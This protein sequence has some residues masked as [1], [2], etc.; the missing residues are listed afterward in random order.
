M[1]FT[2]TLQNG[3]FGELPD[4]C[5]SNGVVPRS[6]ISADGKTLT[7]NLGTREQGTAIAVQTPVVA[8][9][10]TGSQLSATGTIGGQATNLSPISLV[11]EF[12]MDMRWGTPSVYQAPTETY[13]DVDFQWTLNLNRGSEPGPQTIVYDVTFNSAQA[14]AY[15]VGP[16][17]CSPFTG[18]WPADGHPWS[19]G[20][21][22]AE[23]TTSFVDNCTFTQTGPNT[24]RLTL[25]G[26]NYSPASAPTEDST[27]AR[28][29]TD[30]V[31]VA[32]GSI[33]L[34]FNT[35]A[36]N[37]AIDLSAT[38]PAYTS[39]AGNTA[40]DDPSN[41]TSSKSWVGPG[42]YSSALVRSYTGNGGTNWDNTYRVAPG[43]TVRQYL[44]TALQRNVARAD[45]LPVGMCSAL[46][47]R[48]VSYAGL[49][50]F[51]E[52]LSDKEFAPPQGAVI[53]YYTGNAPALDPTSS[54]YDPNAFNCGGDTGW[55]TTAPANPVDVKAVRLTISQGDIEAYS[56]L[57]NFTMN[58]LQTIKP[59]TPAGT[60][61]WSFFSGIMDF[62]TGST[63][64]NDTGCLQSTAGL[65]YPCTTGFRDLLRVVTATPAIEKSAD[66]SVV[67]A[68]VPAT[69]TLAY[70]AN[71]A[72]TIPKTVDSF[73]LIDTL[74]AGMTYVPGSASPEPV[75]TTNGSGQQVLTWTID[76]VATNQNHALTYQA[77]A[78]TSVAPGTTLENSA[79][80]SFGGVTTRPATAQV[81]TST[82]GYTSI[83]KAA[84]TPF[85]PNV[86]G[87]GVGE[88]SWTVTLR[89]FDPLPQTFTD[90][91]DILPYIGDGRGTS[92]SGSYALTDVTAVPGATV[93]YTDAAPATLSDD[94]KD[95][96]NGTPGNITGNKVNWSTT[97]P[98]TVTAVRVIGPALNPG[99]AQA[100][101]VKVATNGVQGGDVLVNRAQARA[102]HTELVMR[103]SAPITV[104]NYYSASL[105][106][107]VQG[108]DGQWHDANTVEDYPSYQV[109][110]KVPYR[111]V[112][113]NTGQGTLTGLKVQDDLFPEGSFTV[114]ELAKGAKETH[115]FTVT[116][117]GGGNV[118]NTACGTADVPADSGV[119]P[120]INCDQA[121]V[122]V[123]NYT[124]AKTSNPASGETVRPGDT[125]TYTIAVTQEGS[126]PAVAQ[127]TD[128]LVDVT[129][130]AVYN[131]DIAA[132]IGN[133]S[134]QNGMISWTGTVPV[135]EVALVTY[136][137]TVKDSAALA[138]DGSYLLANGVQSPGCAVGGCPP[139]KNPVA[140][141]SVVKTSD[142]AT[143]SNVKTGDT[144]KYTVTVS[145][146]GEATYRGAS[147]VDDLSDVFDDASWNND[148]TSTAGTASFDAAQKKL[149][150][151]GDLAVDQ[152]VTLTYS[153]TVLDPAKSAGNTHLQNVVTSEGCVSA[154]TCG[155]E[156]FAASYTT[157]KTANPAAGTDVQVGDTIE[158]TVTVTQSGQGRITGQFFNDDLSKVLDDAT[159]NNDITASAGNF[160]FT[161]GVIA[162]TGDLGPGDVATVKYSVTVTAAG[163][164]VL[165]NTV[166]SPGCASTSH[167]TTEHKTGRFKTVKTSNPATGSSVKAGDT[168]DYTVTVS[169]IGE[170]AVKNASFSDDLTAV[171][172]DATW[173]D[174]L[175]FEGGQATY[176]KPVLKWTGDLSVGQAIKVT[177]SVTVTGAGD[178]TLTNVVTSPGCV[179][180]ADCT[181]THLVGGY[182]VS[183]TSDPANGS[184][185]KAG[186]KITY[187]VQ[188]HQT[189]PGSVTGAVAI[190]D[191]SKVLDDA[192]YNDDAAASAG[193]VGIDKDARKL[194]WTGNLAVGEVVTIT[195]SIKTSALGTGDG[196][197]TNVVTPGIGGICVPAQDQNADCTTTHTVR[198][199]VPVVQDP[200]GPPQPVA[201]APSPLAQTG[202][203]VL[204]GVF[205]ALILLSFGF[206]LLMFR[207]KRNKE[208]AA[209]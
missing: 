113:E 198:D 46:D 142:P 15:G 96:S 68:G 124:V 158:Y 63:W 97:E 3:V 205:V 118:V 132:S 70:S 151:S 7:C 182:T 56:N 57:S 67:T 44:D 112:I 173:H 175:K 55:T 102:E 50:P 43:T 163:D 99:A 146:I 73:Q 37:G 130:D 76:D 30:Q 84:D 54:A 125:V 121:G 47:T 165:G 138:A 104:A 116:L 21:H 137:V 154:A 209:S 95:A 168:I 183:K 152:V 149:S 136:S 62:P 194:T 178:Q 120:S 199:I 16:Q 141:F 22:P 20:N 82:N 14:T 123:T 172:D 64:S 189:G 111:L 6:T 39:T 83:G 35:T 106:K 60:D 58:L 187:T 162:W 51:T 107:Y 42:I 69:F 2:V 101:T 201:S 157:V 81:T 180:T 208:G 23:Q 31:A 179:Q 93:Y 5:L 24:F 115:E 98:A 8:N 196:T 143:G 197:L 117:T 17:A 25:T 75:V 193:N 133:V 34:R 131:G 203:N 160:T 12:G 122:L 206:F 85:I 181:T 13:R 4:V 153:V 10:P 32:S 45:N 61:V 202:V 80:A 195:Y 48:Y 27:G 159:F 59:E 94:P 177:Y 72:G 114:N 171:L 105:K 74:P 77:V 41:N 164:T 88:G 92:Y 188:V 200:A 110:D 148:L 174:N 108:T 90:T 65:R 18:D 169:Q 87:D 161:N 166:T 29:P 135:G 38:A 134:L 170:G 190:D 33:W 144:I 49:G 103:T 167:C 128:S 191:L 156:H 126:A 100:F 119:T 89:S 19:G 91:I 79:V 28:L 40:Q 192:T 66:R 52:G 176:T 78:G 86:N 26:I 9:G 186:D 36:L 155:T 11:S 207:R 145:Q 204:A 184:V 185:V 147:L 109:G 71:G 150:W 127:F 139:V 140:D 53:A 129:D 1:T